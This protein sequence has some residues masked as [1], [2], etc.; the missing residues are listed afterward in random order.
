M[1]S[2]AN[3][4]AAAVFEY[5][6]APVVE[7]A[8]TVLANM[9]EEVYTSRIESW[10]ALIE[11]DFPIYEPIAEWRIHVDQ[12]GGQP[13]VDPTKGELILIPRSSKKSQAEGFD[14]SLRC[15]HGALTMNMHSSPK[16]PRRY[17]DLKAQFAKWLPKWMDHFGVKD[18][19]RLQLI[20]VNIISAATV[21]EFANK[22]GELNLDGVFNVFVNIPGSHKLVVP[23]LNCVATLL[24]EADPYATL[25]IQLAGIALQ[26]PT[27]RLDLST[28]AVLKSGSVESTF[29]LLDWSHD[30]ILERFQNVFTEQARRSFVPLSP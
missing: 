29:E 4:T 5:A 9:P 19:Q 15:P 10:N 1:Q 21:P 12:Q 17:H 24:L 7:R 8:V 26:E 23:P 30:R 27:V 2:T 6:N 13:V 14:W 28:D 16:M 20:Y 18:L 22:P 11:P 3:T 25:T